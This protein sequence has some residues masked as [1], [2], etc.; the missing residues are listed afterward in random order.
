M[1]N[2]SISVRSTFPRSRSTLSQPLSPVLSTTLAHSVQLYLLHLRVCCCHFQSLFS[3]ATPF[4][5]TTLSYSPFS[6]LHSSL[7]VA[8]GYQNQ[9]RALSSYSFNQRTS[10]D[11][12][13]TFRISFKLAK[14]PPHTLSKAVTVLTSTSHSNAAT[15]GFLA[16]KFDPRRFRNFTIPSQF[17]DHYFTRNIASYR[18][19]SSV[20]LALLNSDSLGTSQLE[21]CTVRSSFPLSQ[22]YY[23]SSFHGQ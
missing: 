16:H 2:L 5:A 14:P 7:L 1:S 4:P 6:Q 18:L 12:T 17:V 13:R 11:S 23:F 19:S 21:C 22:I 20:Q 15:D 3:F 9:K 10:L 8:G